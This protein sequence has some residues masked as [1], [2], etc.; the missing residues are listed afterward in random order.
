MIAVVSS[1]PVGEEAANRIVERFAESRGNGQRFAG[2]VSTEVMRSE[3]G[4]E[5]LVITR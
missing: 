1:L 4:D 2:F 5:V 3:E